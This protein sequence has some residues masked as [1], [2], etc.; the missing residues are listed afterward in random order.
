MFPLVP[1]T[2]DN[3]TKEMLRIWI[4]ET[5]E[6]FIANENDSRAVDSIVICGGISGC[7]LVANDRT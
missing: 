6:P 7:K 3:S 4:V 5:I 1:E 2:M